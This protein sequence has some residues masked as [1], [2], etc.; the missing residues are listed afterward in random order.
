M[1]EDPPK[2][3]YTGEFGR[4]ILMPEELIDEWL[5]D[6][7]D[8]VEEMMHLPLEIKGSFHPCAFQSPETIRERT[9]LHVIKTNNDMQTNPHATT[10][11]LCGLPIS[12]NGG[13][14]TDT[15]PQHLI[16]RSNRRPALETEAEALDLMFSEDGKEFPEIDLEVIP[17]EQWPALEYS[18]I[19]IP[20]GVDMTTSIPR[21]EDQLEAILK[22]EERTAGAFYL[23][24]MD[25][26]GRRT[27][28]ILGKS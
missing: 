9:L 6:L 19:K 22:V 7:S 2:C 11:S 13:I 15:G 3:T 27:A 28:R 18:R 24:V 16:C 8:S 25:E 5:D 21:I 1:R 14:P 17:P 20:A 26:D 23:T 4:K 12:A 10:C